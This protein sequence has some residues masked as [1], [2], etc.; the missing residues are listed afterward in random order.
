MSHL[1]VF[2]HGCLHCLVDHIHERVSLPLTRG[3]A[4]FIDEQETAFGADSSWFREVTSSDECLNFSSI[5][6]PKSSF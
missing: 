5:E 3:T 6:A 4:K 2:I 1:A